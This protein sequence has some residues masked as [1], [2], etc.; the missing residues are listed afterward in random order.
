MT[1]FYGGELRQITREGDNGLPTW[2]PDG[3]GIAFVSNRDGVWG[4]WV[5]NADGSHQR[6][7]FTLEPEFG[8]GPVDWTMQRISGRP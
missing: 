6:K 4:L 5:M 3:R 1:P 8:G 2:S 7:I